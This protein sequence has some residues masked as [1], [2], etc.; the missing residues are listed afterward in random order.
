MS[1]TR[2]KVLKIIKSQIIKSVGQGKIGR[3]ESMRTDEGCVT[4]YLDLASA[5]R[6]R[7]WGSGLTVAGGCGGHD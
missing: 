4:T 7:V 5:T 1:N 6:H 3:T 2:V